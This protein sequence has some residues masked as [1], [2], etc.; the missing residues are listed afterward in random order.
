MKIVELSVTL[1]V[2]DDDDLNNFIDDIMDIGQRFSPAI[3]VSQISADEEVED[4]S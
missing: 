3:G 1:S 2:D 4:G